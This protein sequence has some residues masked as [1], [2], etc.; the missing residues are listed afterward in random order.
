MKILCSSHLYKFSCTVLWRLP[1]WIEVSDSIVLLHLKGK[2]HPRRGY[3]G[4]KGEQRYS[5]TVSLI[6]KLD[7]MG[8]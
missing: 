3:E 6:S 1:H 8:G 7:G 2:V 5:S 4:P